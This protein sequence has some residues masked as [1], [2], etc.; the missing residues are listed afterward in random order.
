MFL[1]QKYA[2]DEGVLDSKR[3]CWEETLQNLKGLI[4]ED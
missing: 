2:L 1:F 3:I 4:Q